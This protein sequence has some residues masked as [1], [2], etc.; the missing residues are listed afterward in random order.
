MF[1]S[2]R[3]IGNA[4]STLAGRAFALSGFS[5]PPAPAALSR[6]VRRAIERQRAKDANK[7]FRASSRSK[8]GK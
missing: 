1:K 6:Q 2:V 8:G 4:L 3:R 5:P 7:A